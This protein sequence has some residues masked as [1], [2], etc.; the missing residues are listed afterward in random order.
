M[1]FHLLPASVLRECKFIL[2]L[3]KAEKNPE[4]KCAAEEGHPVL[5]KPNRDDFVGKI[6]GLRF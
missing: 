1:Y 2:L 5:S 6:M 3:A 4:G